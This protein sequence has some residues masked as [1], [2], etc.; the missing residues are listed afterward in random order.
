VQDAMIGGELL[1]HVDRGAGANHRHQIWWLQL[2][3]HE[4]VQGIPGRGHA[5][6]RHAE[7][8]HDQDDG[9]LDCR[10]RGRGGDSCSVGR[11]GARTGS[12]RPG[13]S[14]DVDPS[15]QHHLLGPP[16]LV[17]VKVV[18]C[19]I[20]DELAV[21]VGHDHVDA[22]GIN[23]H[24]EGGNRLGSRLLRRR[25]LWRGARSGA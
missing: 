4:R 8:V 21:L 13:R 17:D 15:R 19:Q 20:G 5:F 7:V 1:H 24:A 25:A 16:A 6:E 12:R 2:A 14:R 11:S 9:P 3:V 23:A 18:G 10:R 22:D